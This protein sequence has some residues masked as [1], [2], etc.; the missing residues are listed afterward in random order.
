MGEKNERLNVRLDEQK[1]RVG[2]VFPLPP[3][4]PGGAE[5]MTFM[6]RIFPNVFCVLFAVLEWKK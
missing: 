4:S 1:R 5:K 2:V 3:T 6:L